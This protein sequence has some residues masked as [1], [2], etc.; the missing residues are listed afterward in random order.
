MLSKKDKHGKIAKGECQRINLHIFSLLKLTFGKTYLL[1]WGNHGMLS[2]F[3]PEFYVASTEII[4]FFISL[5]MDTPLET[6]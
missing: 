3:M 4:T 6:S 5:Y 2:F 1:F